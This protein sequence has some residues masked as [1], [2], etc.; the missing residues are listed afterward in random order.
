MAQQQFYNPRQ[1]PKEDKNLYDDDSTFAPGKKTESARAASDKAGDALDDIDSLLAD[2]DKF[3]EDSDLDVDD[4][5]HAE[6]NAGSEDASEGAVGSESTSEHTEDEGA[7]TSQTSPGLFIDKGGKKSG[8]GSGIFTRKRVLYGGGAGIAVG[9][10]IGLFMFFLPG[11][12]LEG[13]L[14]RINDRAFGYAESAVERRMGVLLERY[15][16]TRVFASLDA[17]GTHVTKNCSAAYTDAGM[18]TSLFNK[19]RDAGLEE[20]LLEKYGIEITHNENAGPDDYRYF[21]QKKS[22]G[23]LFSRPSDSQIKLK[24]GDIEDVGWL[25]NGGTDGDTGSRQLGRELNLRFKQESRWHDVLERRGLRRMLKA[26]YDVKFWCFAACDTR[27][28]IERK[29]TNATTRLK[30]WATE[31]YVYPNSEKMGL[32]FDCI[33][34]GSTGGNCSVESVRNRGFERLDDRAAQEIIDEFADG[35][36]GKKLTQIIVKTVAAKYLPEAAATSVTSSVPIAGQIY[37]A[38]VVVDLLDR[39]DASIDSRIVSKYAADLSSKV[40]ADHYISMRT[41]NDELK[42]GKLSTDDVGAI[43]NLFAGA[44]ESLVFQA[45]NSTPTT[46][47]LGGGTAY[48]QSSDG[49]NDCADGNP[50]PTGELVCDEQKIDREFFFERW[51]DNFGD[52]LDA[53]NT[54][55]SCMGP[56]G[57]MPEVLGRCPG[58]RLSTVVRPLINGIN[59]LTS[60]VTETALNAVESTPGVGSILTSIQSFVGNKLERLVKPIFERIFP[61]P[62]TPDSS[63]AKQ[64]DGLEAGAEV[65]AFEWA[66]GGYDDETGEAHGLGAERL[67]PEESGAIRQQHADQAQYE[68]D[69]SS[70]FEQFAD[71]GNPR[72]LLNT[73]AVS[74]P[75]SPKTF[76]KGIATSMPTFFGRLFGTLTSPSVGAQSSGLAESPFGVPTYGYTADDPIFSM[77][78]AELTEE[79]CEEY[80]Q[81]WE[82]SMTESESTGFSEYSTTNPCLLEQ[83]VV[84][85]GGSLF[86]NEDDGGIN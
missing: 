11:L 35:R 10:A 69:N 71:A 72:S 48:A 74:V 77:D 39:I 43:N 41:M 54:Y 2:N 25:A 47:F 42:A 65:I 84:E 66:K 24:A 78:P 19:W 26:K 67:T 44:E 4:I 49:G 1:Q 45:N 23:S 50:I 51:R 27:D 68:H 82:D 13:Y 32:Y 36:T 15:I 22:S 5:K 63:G 59:S 3:R 18:A 70:L 17:C 40:Y 79:R 29:Y 20:T 14:S 76:A 31:R 62:V 37:A 64:Y 73:L 8:T 34:K 85:S 86:T 53:V 60:A 9:G 56:I 12:R 46:A 80:R 57:P 16:T 38:L 33:I 52:I 30:Y 58:I 21:I 81:T 75:S 7:D 55:D 83:S 6:E 61:F 28:S